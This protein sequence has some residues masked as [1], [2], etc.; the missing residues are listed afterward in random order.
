MGL[1]RELLISVLC[2]H[3]NRAN[4]TIAKIIHITPPNLCGILLK[5]A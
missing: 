3:G 2:I 5:I 1:K 4:T